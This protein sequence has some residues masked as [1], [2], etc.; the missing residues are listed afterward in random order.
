MPFEQLFSDTLLLLQPSFKTTDF[1][2]REPIVFNVEWP[3]VQQGDKKHLLD[4]A[5]FSESLLLFKPAEMLNRL[6]CFLTWNHWQ[7]ELYYWKKTYPDYFNNDI[8]L[9]TV[10]KMVQ[11][12]LTHWDL[13]VGLNE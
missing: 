11:C 8:Q 5:K 12:S 4:P 2:L 3:F 10:S 9:A 1:C 6:N 7:R 13:T